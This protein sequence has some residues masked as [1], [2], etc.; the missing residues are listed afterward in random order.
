MVWASGPEGHLHPK[1]AP[2]AV[3]AA[4]QRAGILPLMRP[5]LES[6]VQLW[7]SQHK[8]D[9]DLLELVQRRPQRC[10][11]GWSISA[12]ERQAIKVEVVQ[13]G[14]VKGNLSTASST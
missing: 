10:S 12:K 3:E 14:E 2:K 6:W 11:E 13:P 9:V 8:K 7:I 5:H 4:C 1:A